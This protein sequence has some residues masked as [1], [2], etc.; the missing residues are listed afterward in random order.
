[1]LEEVENNMDRF[2][3]L[4]GESKKAEVL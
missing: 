3:K 1:M 2:D 4:S